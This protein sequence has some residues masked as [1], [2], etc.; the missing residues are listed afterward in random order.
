[1]D[2]NHSEV[3][4][5]LRQEESRLLRQTATEE[6]EVVQEQTPGQA[7]SVDEASEAMV[8]QEDGLTLE[9]VLEG[10][11]DDVRHALHNLDAGTYGICDDCG[12]PIPAARLEARPQTTL[13]LPCKTKR[14]HSHSPDRLLSSPHAAGVA[15]VLEFV[16]SPGPVRTGR[17]CRRR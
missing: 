1:M 6:H 5:E 4:N 16:E 3:R 8:A 2:K 14:E 17:A 9:T 12:Q 7:V 15:E 13:C 11:L 10:A